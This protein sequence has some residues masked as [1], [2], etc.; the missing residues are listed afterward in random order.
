MAHAVDSRA[1]NPANQ[2]RELL[3]EVE[4]LSVK[5]SADTVEALLLKLDEIESLFAGMAQEGIDLLS[6]RVR[7]QNIM[8]RLESRP[9]LIANAAA[10]AGGLASLRAAYAPATGVWWR[11]DEI[12]A[13]RTRSSL[14]R[15]VSTLVLVVGGIALAFWLFNTLF[16]P[17][18]VAVAVM[19][20]ASAVDRQVTEQ[21]WPAAFAIAEQALAQYPNEPELLIWAAVLAE[22]LKDPQLVQ[23]YTTQAQAQMGGETVRFWL[24][25]GMTRMRVNDM[26]GARAAGE[27]AILID[28]NNPEGYFLAGNVASQTGDY[29]IA[30]EYLDKTYTLAEKSNPQLAV[31][32]RMLWGQILQNPNLGMPTEEPAPATSPIS[33]TV[34]A[35]TP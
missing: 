33:T 23:K 27:T 14:I 28:P 26:P 19:E 35:Q 20:A 10:K 18:P 7:W 4:R 32:A 21:D 9:E 30:L 13:Q 31:N 5:P 12:R 6:E 3:D 16:P 29:A 15:T 2:L 8:N 22:Q 1:S 25:M 11:A 17:D 24:Q 34:P